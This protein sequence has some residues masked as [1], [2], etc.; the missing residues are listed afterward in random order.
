MKRRLF[1]QHKLNYLHIFIMIIYHI[2]K[3]HNIVF[4]KKAILYKNKAF[5]Q[6]PLTFLPL[7]TKIRVTGYFSVTDSTPFGEERIKL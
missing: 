3:Y 7:S 5:F 4:V 2:V 1:I 6:K